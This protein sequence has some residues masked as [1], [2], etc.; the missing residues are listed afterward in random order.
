MDR[1]ADRLV[2]RLTPEHG[3]RPTE[4]EVAASGAPFTGAL[5]AAAQS[6]LAASDRVISL[7]VA[8]RSA[9]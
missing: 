2:I 9:A 3:S 4:P 6:A 1:R 8:A 5:A 7:E